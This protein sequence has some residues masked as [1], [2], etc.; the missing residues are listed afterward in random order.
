MRELMA[1]RFRHDE[2]SPQR[3]SE[4]RR[5]TSAAI[6]SVIDQRAEDDRFRHDPL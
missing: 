6:A 4:R 5:W 1:P 2:I 3:F